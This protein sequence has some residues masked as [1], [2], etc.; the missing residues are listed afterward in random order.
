M[1][2]SVGLSKEHYFCAVNVSGGRQN[3]GRGAELLS[4]PHFLC[5]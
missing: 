4:T 1:A 5:R 3:F 2:I